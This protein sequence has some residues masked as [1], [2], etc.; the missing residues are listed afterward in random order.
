MTV[1]AY[2]HANLAKGTHASCRPTA[3]TSPRLPSHAENAEAVCSRATYWNVTSK[4]EC[5]LEQQRFDLE[6]NLGTQVSM[7]SMKHYPKHGQHK[8][9]CLGTLESLAGTPG[10][11]VTAEC[12]PS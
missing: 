11:D 6:L 5:L 9:T 1:S 12:R 2:L 4:W 8:C 3:L 7:C 10:L